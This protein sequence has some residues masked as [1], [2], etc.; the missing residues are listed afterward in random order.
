MFDTR[1][2]EVISSITSVQSFTNGKPGF[3]IRAARDFACDVVIAASTPATREVSGSVYNLIASLTSQ[4]L[5]VLNPFGGLEV[6]LYSSRLI[7][8]LGITNP[9]IHALGDLTSGA[10][11]FIF[12]LSAQVGRADCIVRD[13]ASVATRN[14][15]NNLKRHK[16]AQCKI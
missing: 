6:D 16:P 8:R 12:G 3:E 2:L 1:Q 9:R 10:Y 4:G 11:F 5:A 14:P 15:R 13:I 7:N